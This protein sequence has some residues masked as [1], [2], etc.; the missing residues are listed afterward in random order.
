[1]DQEMAFN[2]MKNYS[3]KNYGVLMMFQYSSLSARIILMTRNNY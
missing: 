1:M 3:I 2:I